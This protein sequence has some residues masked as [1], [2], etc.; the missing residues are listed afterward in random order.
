MDKV[1]LLKFDRNRGKGGAV[2]M[3]G[4]MTVTDSHAQHG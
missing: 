2:R 4:H 3:V 1:R